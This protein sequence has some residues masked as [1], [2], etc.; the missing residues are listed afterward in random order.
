LLVEG[1]SLRATARIADV[2]RNTTNKLL[3]DVG[4]A[5]LDYQDKYPVNLP[6]KRIQ[7]D[8]IWSFVYAKQENV[9]EELRPIFGYGD[10]WTSSAI[11]ADTKP[12]PCWEVGPRD[13]DAAKRFMDNLAARMRYVPQLATDGHRAYLEAWRARSTAT[14]TMPSL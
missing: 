11:C 7:C 4:S 9:P 13:A 12:V 5:C 1:N 3:N 14:W 6:Y 8:E 2:S 10:V